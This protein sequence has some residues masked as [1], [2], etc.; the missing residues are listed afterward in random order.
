MSENM[1]PQKVYIHRKNLDL[2]EKCM[3]KEEP[4]LLVFKGPMI[5]YELLSKFRKKPRQLWIVVFNNQQH[6]SH[7]FLFDHDHRRKMNNIFMILHHL[8]FYKYIYF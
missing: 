5:P 4:V 2:N 7:S 6:I 1:F 8:A 3:G